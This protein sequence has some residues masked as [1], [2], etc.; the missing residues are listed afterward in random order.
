MPAALVLALAAATISAGG[1]AAP[2]ASRCCLTHRDHAGV[3]VVVPG[4]GESC[5]GILAYL[6]S[7]HT[8]GRTY[9][10][11]TRIRGGWRTVPCP[12]APTPAPATAGAPPPA[13]CSGAP[14]H[15]AR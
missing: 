1:A 10:G 12:P 5:E 3:C 4:A 7:P 11:G 6:N 9:C 15:P 8:A 13:P 2:A 14:G